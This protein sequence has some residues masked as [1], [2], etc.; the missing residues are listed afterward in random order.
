MDATDRPTSS[1]KQPSALGAWV[2]RNPIALKE[3]RGRMRGARAFIVLTV[4]VTLMS[5][6]TVILYLIYTASMQVTLSTSGGVIGKM[7]FGGVVAVELFLVCFIAPAF[8]SSAIS[9]ERERQ[10]YNLLRTTLLPARRIITGK[11][12]AALAYVLLLLFVAVPLQ[13]LAFLMGGVTIEEVLL[14][15][16]LLAVTAVAYG[17]IGIFFSAATKRTLS[18]SVLTYVFAL[19]ITVVLPLASLALFGITEAVVYS[20][21]DPTQ[22]AL[23]ETLLYYFDLLV[24]ATNPIATGVLTE[25]VLLQHGTALFYSQTVANGSLIPAVSPW[26]VYTLLYGIVTL[27][28]IALSVRKV[29]QIET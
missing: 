17:T 7:I 14:S 18:A 24:A 21:N 15:I 6:F 5:L 29:R 26:I 13:S 22:A 23:V 19:M 27:V 1:T 25:I 8:T 3:L 16:E 2:R 9:G 10:T 12:M 11:L 4:Y 28:L 20:M